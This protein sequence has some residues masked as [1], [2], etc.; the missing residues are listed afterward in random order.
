MKSSKIYKGVIREPLFNELG[1][2]LTTDLERSL[3]LVHG[4]YETLLYRIYDNIYKCLMNDNLYSEDCIN[5]DSLIP[6]DRIIDCGRY[7][8]KKR[9]VKLYKDFLHKKL[10]IDLV[11]IGKVVLVYDVVD[12]DNAFV[13][14][15]VMIYHGTINDVKF[16][17]EFIKDAVLYK[18]DKDTY[19][20]LETYIEYKTADLNC[21][22]YTVIDCRPFVINDIEQN[23]ELEQS[24]ILKKFRK[25]SY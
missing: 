20:D 18:L 5:L 19:L 14:D 11:F 15:N 1:I 4:G 7:V 24:K 6:F 21:G 25:G 3:G 10:S 22:K 16:K 13:E 9:A 17:Y 8:T 23:K 12:N 2:T